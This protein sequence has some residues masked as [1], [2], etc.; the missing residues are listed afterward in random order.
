MCGSETS[1][2][3]GAE[4]AQMLERRVAALANRRVET[5]GKYSFGGPIDDALQS[6]ASSPSR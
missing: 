6:S 2:I 1:R 4:R 3:V 5:A